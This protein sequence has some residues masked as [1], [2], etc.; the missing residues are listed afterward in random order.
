MIKPRLFGSMLVIYAL[1]SLFLGQNFF[2]L[3]ALFLAKSLRIDW[4]TTTFIVVMIPVDICYVIGGIGLVFLKRW[5]RWLILVSVAVPLIFNLSDFILSRYVFPGKFKTSASLISFFTTF[6]LPAI[7]HFLILFAALVVKIPKVQSNR[8]A[9][10]RPGRDIPMIER[11]LVSFA[12]RRQIRQVLFGIV[13]GIA[14]ALLFNSMLLLW[15][16]GSIVY[17]F[18]FWFVVI[19]IVPVFIVTKIV[20]FMSRKGWLPKAPWAVIAFVAIV[21][22]PFCD[23]APVTLRILHLR[24][25]ANQEIPLYPDAVKE[26]TFVQPIANETTGCQYVTV[27]LKTSAGQKEIVRFYQEELSRLGWDLSNETVPFSDNTP[28]WFV[29]NERH[30][31]VNVAVPRQVKV[32]YYMK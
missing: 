20:T 10:A 31:S 17:F 25:I 18:T 30:I 6:Y 9:I 16:G 13:L 7:P 1:C 23:Y 5:S 32:T 27:V 19:F 24:S 4:Q 12:T 22:W 26:G 14:T 21:G 8:L 15:R 28:Y 2:Y 29:K 11:F 3:S